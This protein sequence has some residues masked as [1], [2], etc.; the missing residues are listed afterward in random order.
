MSV[1]YVD[2]QVLAVIAPSVRKALDIDHAH[3]GWLVSAFSMAY[4]VAAPLSGI[5]VDRY[6]ARR[7]FAC[8][9]LA[10]SCV[11]AGHALAPSFAVLF[12][13][14]VLL[15][16]S[17][18]PAFPSAALA[19][20]RA[21]PDARRSL[22]FGLLFTGSSI[23]AVIA[24]L[25]AVPLDARY[26]YRVA[27]F[28]T[29]IVG[30]LWLPLWLLVTRQQAFSAARRAPADAL[31]WWRVAQ[32]AAVLRALVAI[33]GSAPGIMLCLNFAS[34]YLVEHWHLAKEGLGRYL[35]V[36][37]L[38]FDLGALVFGALATRRE[39]TLAPAAKLPTHRALLC[40]A[41]VLA[42]CLALIPLA[43]SAWQ[44]IALMSVTVCGGGAIYALVT[45]DMLGRVPENRTSTAGGLIAASQSLAIIVASPIAGYAIDRSRGYDSA[46]I[47]CGLVVLPAIVAFVLWPVDATDSAA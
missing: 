15:G 19:I 38:C 32:S 34:Q 42:A 39:R 21:L 30:A 41:A 20:R 9:V 27:F 46:M 24:G 29:G 2:R 31:P 3:F 25:A 22:A 16:A 5:L 4:L 33:V 8:A 23:G 36:P 1:S 43:T 10:W 13:L 18:A 17:E 35:I 6:G 14:R 47:A 37:P 45:A 44:S 7:S 26:G 40:F 28:V 11:A 12:L